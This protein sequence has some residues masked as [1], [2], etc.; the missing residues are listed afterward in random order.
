MFIEATKMPGKG[1]LKLT[2]RLGDVMK[3]SAQAAFSYIR[4]NTKLYG[5][6]ESFYKKYDIHIH[7]PA[8]AIPKDGPSAGVAMI[9]SMVS[10]LTDTPLK[11]FLGMTGEISLRGNV[12]PIGGLKEKSTAAHRAGLKHIIA[13]YLNEKDLEEIPEKVKKDIKITF[14]KEVQDVIKLALDI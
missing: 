8:G 13:P 4:S 14:V 9:A 12:L 5:I 3:E 1:V 11:D 2:G 10:L 7:V 6:D